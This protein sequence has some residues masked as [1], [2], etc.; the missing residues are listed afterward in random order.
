MSIDKKTKTIG[1]RSMKQI[2]YNYCTH[3][4]I[5]DIGSLSDILQ[6]IGF[7]KLRPGDG[8]GLDDNIFIR[9]VV[10]RIAVYA[11]DPVDNIHALD[12]HAECRICAVKVRSIRMHNKELTACAVIGLVKPC[13]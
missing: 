5:S 3:M 4:G 10:H 12:D 8:D 2:P 7:G 1:I 6:L 9:M 11:C 13:H